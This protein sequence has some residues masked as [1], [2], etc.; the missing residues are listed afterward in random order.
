VD[1]QRDLAETNEAGVEP[2]GSQQ[3]RS[4]L[5]RHALK[6]ALSIVIAIGF[7]VLLK[8]GA[9]PLVP[10]KETFGNVKWWTVA[11]YIALWLVVHF[12]RAGRW[13]WLLAA[14]HR[15]PLR[16]VMGVA[17]I[18]FAALVVFPL[19]MGEVVRP[20]MIRKKGHL[21]AWAATGTVGAERIIDGLALSVIL[22]SALQLAKPL[23]PLP[24]RIGNL[25]V[26]AAVVPGAAYVA[27]LVFAGAFI[28]MSLFYWR[29]AFARRLTERV[30]GIVSKPLGSWLADRL[31]QV[32][33]GLTFLPRW[34]LTA[35]FLG[36][37]LVYWLLNAG[38]SWLLAW[39][40][41]F[42]NI[43]FAQTCAN[44]GVLALGI[45][46]P[47]APG[48]FGAYQ[49]SVYAG[50]AMYFTPEQVV[51]PGSAYVF[52]M[53]LSQLTI[54]LLCGVIAMAVQRTSLSETL[55]VAPELEQPRPG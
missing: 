44:M 19:R 28:V 9:L 34:R 12:V 49:I 11:A 39:G 20:M 4:F 27:L 24:D 41:G 48:F 52:I 50:F 1:P 13:Y 8:A 14:V 37:T 7:G 46:L 22:F 6:L 33:S 40:C 2:V 32:A 31:E 5:R 10:S 53:Y 54:T 47:N 38:S 17:F 36:A 25:P 30:A 26:P 45:L 29:R 3:N 18:G 55:E 43:T 42:E 51:G 35:P 21:T 15:V 23:D 16:R